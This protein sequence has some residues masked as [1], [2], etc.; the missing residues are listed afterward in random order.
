MTI[1]NVTEIGIPYA[2]NYYRSHTVTTYA[3]EVKNSKVLRPEQEFQMTQYDS[4]R[5][6]LID[7]ADVAISFG[8]IGTCMFILLPNTECSTCLN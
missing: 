8:Y 3:K 1:G 2:L 7:Y 4:I 6:A 5:A